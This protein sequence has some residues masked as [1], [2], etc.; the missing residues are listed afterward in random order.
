[1]EE[2]KKFSNLKEEGFALVEVL[3]SIMI[4]GMS[5]VVLLS[6]QT[7][8]VRKTIRDRNH[9]DAMLVARSIMSAIEIDIDRLEEQEI[10]MPAQQMIRELIGSESNEQDEAEEE[11][12]NKYNANL[13]VTKTEIPVPL[14]N[15]E[16]IRLKKILLNLT[17]S[18]NP[19]DRLETVFFV[20]D[21][22]QL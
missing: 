10:N 1:M 11:F 3:I 4:L 15:I 16:P 18:E 22:D 8:A 19:Q 21:N 12:L 2:V 9:Q 20:P 17:W 7:A 14:P 5:F 6:L 13:S